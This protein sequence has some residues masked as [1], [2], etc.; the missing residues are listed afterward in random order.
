MQYKFRGKRKDNGEWVY[1]SLTV[2]YDGTCHINYWVSKLIEPENNFW[3]PV[4]EM[5]EVIPETV[6][7]WTGLKDKNGKEI[8]Q[9][10]LLKHTKQ[11][12]GNF[13]DRLFERY[14]V[15]YNSAVAGFEYKPID[16]KEYKQYTTR[17]FGGDEIEIIGNVHEVKPAVK[18]SVTN[19]MKDLD[20]NQQQEAAGQA[21]AEAVNEQATEGQKEALESA[22]Q[23]E[24]VGADAEEGGTEG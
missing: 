2:E 9:G 12:D 24:A 14:E 1:G 13:I 19:T 4:H 10:D 3:E 11:I 23:D 18:D 16:G 21:N 7:M 15:D 8:Y 6:G 22:T 17:P 5:A 20:P